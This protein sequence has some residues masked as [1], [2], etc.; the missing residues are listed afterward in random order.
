MGSGARIPGL[1]SR[2]R[3]F[4]SLWNLDYGFRV[5]GIG[6]SYCFICLCN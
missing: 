4:S 6:D 1:E 2:R 3:S 5:N